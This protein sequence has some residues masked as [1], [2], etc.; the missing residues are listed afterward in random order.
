VSLAADEIL[1]ELVDLSRIVALDVYVDDAALS[2][3]A[4]RYPASIPRLRSNVEQILAVRPD[5][6]CASFYNAQDF[7]EVLAKSGVP[8]FRYDA[9]KSFDGIRAGIVALG[10][11]VG[12]K[13]KAEGIVA[14]MDRRLAA[15]AKAIDGVARPRVLYW[16]AGWT[17]G[18]GS[19]ID[20]LI[21]RAGGRNVG[22]EIGLEGMTQIPLERALAADPDVLLLDAR[23][24]HAELRGRDLPPQ[25]ETLRAMKE[26]RDVRIPGRALGA[27]S[28]HV[29]DGV[30]A[31]ARA[32]HADRFPAAR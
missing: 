3:V 24:A 4:G 28:H 22:A 25:L 13:A 7:L 12:A 10:E 20:E 14:D 26:G 5:L 31:L 29:V 32:L 15:V 18:K 8:S 27:V 21:D 9:V 2:N 19:S 30:E 17:A 1:H 23:D 11:R 6:V 16:S